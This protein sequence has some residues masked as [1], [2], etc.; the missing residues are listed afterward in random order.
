MAGDGTLM[1]LKLY[2][3]SAT[4]QDEWLTYIHIKFSEVLH[5]KV[6]PCIN[7]FT[8][9]PIATPLDK[10][11][12][13]TIIKTFRALK[14]ECNGVGVLEVVYSDYS[15]ECSAVWRKELGRIMFQPNL[16][17]ASD[18]YFVTPREGMGL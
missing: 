17:T 10:D 7:D 8:A 12:V 13:W 9:F 11:K 5:F 16:D 3:R 1:A 4:Q 2:E 6:W 15:E 14:I 18:G